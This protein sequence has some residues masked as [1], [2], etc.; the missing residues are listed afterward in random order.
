VV[1]S[2][3]M[4]ERFLQQ[5]QVSKPVAENLLTFG[6]RSGIV[7]RSRKRH[8]RTNMAQKELRFRTDRL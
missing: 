1:G 2:R 8:G 7:P 6:Q 5:S 3:S 4:N